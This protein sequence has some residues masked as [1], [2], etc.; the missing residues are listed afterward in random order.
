MNS[1]T[2]SDLP[3]EPYRKLHTLSQIAYHEINFCLY[4][5][6]KPSCYTSS[7]KKLLNF[8]TTSN[9]PDSFVKAVWT[10]W[11]MWR[12]SDK[13]CCIELL[14]WHTKIYFRK[15]LCILVFLYLN[16]HH[17]KSAKVPDNFLVWRHCKHRWNLY[18]LRCLCDSRCSS[19]VRNVALRP[20]NLMYIEPLFKRRAWIF[21]YQK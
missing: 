3:L 1:F 7:L 10:R 18:M 20:S 4:F 9:K 19:G 14:N 15:I 17:G 21:F 12:E 11:R 5:L 8:I 16:H 6:Y 13:R 2:K